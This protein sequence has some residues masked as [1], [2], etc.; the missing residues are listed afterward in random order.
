[1]TFVKVDLEARGKSTATEAQENPILDRKSPL[2]CYL[3]SITFLL[4]DN[5]LRACES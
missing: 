2:A 1:M 4:S 3:P 5:Y